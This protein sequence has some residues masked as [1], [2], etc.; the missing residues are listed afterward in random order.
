MESLSMPDYSPLL[1]KQRR[2]SVLVQAKRFRYSPRSVVIAYV[3][4]SNVL[5][6][7]IVGGS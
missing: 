4:N 6:V 2:N 3:T 7:Q 1:M 5:S